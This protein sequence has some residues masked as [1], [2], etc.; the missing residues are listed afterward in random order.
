MLWVVDRVLVYDCQCSVCMLVFLGG[1]YY[2]LVQHCEKGDSNLKYM[3]A[4]WRVMGKTCMWWH[5]CK[6]YNTLLLVR[7]VPSQWNVQCL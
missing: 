2:L 6:N 1:C 5:F 7:C 4:K 3:S